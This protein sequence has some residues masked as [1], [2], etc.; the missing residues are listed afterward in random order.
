MR[1]VGRHLPRLGKPCCPEGLSASTSY[2][3][4]RASSSWGRS[5]ARLKP[6][7]GSISGPSRPDESGVCPRLRAW[8]RWQRWGVQNRNQAFGIGGYEGATALVSPFQHYWSLAVDEQFYIVLPLCLTAGA[9]GAMKTGQIKKSACLFLFSALSSASCPIA[10]SSR[11]PAT[12]SLNSPPPNGCENSGWAAFWGLPLAGCK[13]GSGWGG[14]WAG[15]AT[16]FWCA[17]AFSASTDFPGYVAVLP[18]AAPVLL[19]AAGTAPKADGAGRSSATSVLGVASA[20]YVGDISYSLYLWPGPWS[21]SLFLTGQATGIPSRVRNSCRRQAV[22]VA[23]YYLVEQ[24][25]GIA[26][27]C[28]GRPKRSPQ[29]ATPAGRLSSWPPAHWRRPSW[30]PARPGESSNRN[31]SIKTAPVNLRQYPGSMALDRGRPAAIPS[32]LVVRPD[33]AG[34]MTDVVVTGGNECGAFD[35]A[36]MG[37]EKCRYGS[38]DAGK[39]MIIVG[40]SHAAQLVDRCCWWGSSRDATST[41]WSGTGAPTLWPRPS[42]PTRFSTAVPTRTGRRWAVSCALGPELVVVSAM[43]PAGYQRALYRHSV[44]RLRCWSIGTTT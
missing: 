31:R 40:D 25:S 28:G 9:A 17:L 43:T 35:P 7:G 13:W 41:R 16:V 26:W 4:S 3:S 24:G 36:K 32:G 42:S 37:E 5:S 15:L 39:T 18:A 34:A 21:F 38:A 10:S 14:F 27:T 1:P 6:P 29:P 2:P 11:P 44:S 22:A 20:R 8:S 30:P 23:S 19:L 12:M 33:P